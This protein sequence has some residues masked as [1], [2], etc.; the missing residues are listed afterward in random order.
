MNKLG[1]IRQIKERETANDVFDTPISLA[2]LL[3]EMAEI[4]ESDRVLDP[5][6]GTGIFFDNLPP[7]RK[8]YCEITEGKDFFDYHESA[9][10]IIGNPPFSQLK[11]WLEHSAILCP[12]KICYVLGCLNLTPQ[13][14]SFL[15]RHG[16]KLTKIHLT[17]VVGWFGNILCVVFD[18]EGD[19]CMTYDVIRH[20]SG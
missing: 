12:R 19:D 7:C 6:R 2:K 20:K 5:C 4:K 13:R 15:K 3:I 8:D 10:V 1:K 16:Y 18:K 9:D 17:T 11:Q 14:V